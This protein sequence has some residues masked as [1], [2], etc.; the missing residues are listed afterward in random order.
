MKTVFRLSILLSVVPLCVAG[1]SIN[2]QGRVAAGGNDYTGPAWLKARAISMFDENLWASDGSSGTGEPAGSVQ[3][4][5]NNGLFSIELGN[6]NIPGMTAMDWKVFRDS[7]CSLKIWLSTN[8][9]TFEQLSPN[10]SVRPATFEKLSSGRT[11]FVDDSDSADFR[12]LQDALDAV[13]N[14]EAESII[15]LPGWYSLTTPLNFSTQR[16]VSITGWGN[17]DEIN[18]ECTNG[19]AMYLQNARLENI[20]V[21]GS[22]AVSDDDAGVED[23]SWW[24]ADHCVFR[25]NSAVA[26]GDS[27]IELSGGGQATLFDCRIENQAANVGYALELS[28]S[29]DIRLTH[30]ELFSG[31]GGAAAVRITGD[32]ILS[33]G[34]CDFFSDESRSLDIEAPVT[35]WLD[36][37]DCRLESGI[38]FGNSAGG[39]LA[40]GT[41][42]RCNFGNGSG[43]EFSV[44]IDGSCSW[45]N[46]ENCS[47]WAQDATAVRLFAEAG[48]TAYVQMKN[49]DI[50]AQDS[51]AM[52]LGHG[53]L[54]TNDAGNEMDSAQVILKDCDV[55]SG[56]GYGVSVLGAWAQV[57]STRVQCEE[58]YA[59]KAVNAEAD[60]E[61][62]DL[63]G[64]V[65]IVGG[66]SEI[67]VTHSS[68]EGELHGM[69]LEDCMAE[70]TESSVTGGQGSGIESGTSDGDSEL[71]I[72]RSEIT[73][74]DSDEGTPDGSAVVT[75]FFRTDPLVIFH[76]TLDNFSEKPTLNI[77]GGLCLIEESIILAEAGPAAELDS[78]ALIYGTNTY[79]FEHCKFISTSDSGTNALVH[80][81][82]DGDDAINP[83][84]NGCAFRS[85][86]GTGAPAIGMSTNGTSTTAAVIMADCYLGGVT[87]NTN[88]ITFLP[89][90][91]TTLP[92]GNIIGN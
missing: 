15:I 24:Q 23:S 11:I 53:V 69:F 78:E 22:P 39:N 34:S 8:S 68:V 65:G 36:I 70:V 9:T 20:S 89:V 54:V 28:G 64:L 31:S 7:E 35:T 83:V 67:E 84:F 88:V 55:Y 38:Y 85:L 73:G 50:S 49:C 66:E 19:P 48:A 56:Y 45:L 57:V 80:L 12:D 87:F 41:I 91:D 44:N 27:A 52:I 33:A 47:V 32:P 21:S 79:V 92:Y 26:A 77:M 6:S 86:F 10:V 42:S 13:F 37:K 30:C 71:F 29:V 4:E 62:S 61:Y 59:I 82:E 58:G 72:T 1:A 74:S 5:V 18:I 2:Y 43:E 76:S 81:S 25:N 16:F 75:T 51:G 14:D 46:F 63:E 60:V 17:R 3:I 40:G 90:D